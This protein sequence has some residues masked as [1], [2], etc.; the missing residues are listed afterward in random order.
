M[1]SKKYDFSK[2]VAVEITLDSLRKTIE[3]LKANPPQGEPDYYIGTYE[4]WVWYK[5][6]ILK[7]ED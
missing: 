4:D 3:D 6:E 1:T 5:R 2:V 7:L